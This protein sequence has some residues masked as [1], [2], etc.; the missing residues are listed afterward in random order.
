MMGQGRFINF[1]KCT[2]LVEDIDK[3]G[4]AC[5]GGSGPWENAAILSFTMNLKLLQN[6]F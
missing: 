6:L 3:G 1:N 4:G 5:V 2:I